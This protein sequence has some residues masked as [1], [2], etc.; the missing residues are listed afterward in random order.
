MAIANQ[1]LHGGAAI[2]IAAKHVEQHAVRNLKAGNQP[3][4]RRIDQAGE[5]LFIPIN[6]IAF[7]CLALKRFAA[8]AGGFFREAQIFD[9]VFRRLHD[10]PAFVIET[11]AS[12][13]AADLM[14]ISRGQNANLLAIELAE[15][16]E[17]HSADG[18]VNAH[19]QRVGAADDL[20]EALLR[21]LFYEHAVLGQQAGVMQADAVAQPFLDV[22][23]VGAAE[24]ETFDGLRNGVLLFA[25]REIETGEILRALAGFQLGKV[26]DVG[27][28]PTVL[29]KAFDR[30][31]E[32]QFRVGVFKRHRAVA[33]GHGHRG[34]AVQPG[35]RL[36]KKG[37]VAERGGHEQKPRLRHG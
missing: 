24:A 18:D 32:R 35:Q 27:G 20:E 5:G 14:K 11:L 28:H 4:G 16:R 33:G 2:A 10:H 25:G 21:E 3:F 23:S 17:E 8:V 15:T 13:A 22:G 1:L 7:R 12:G 26:N 36:L 37:G 30:L 9:H 19:A 34:F 6:E 31:G 29:G